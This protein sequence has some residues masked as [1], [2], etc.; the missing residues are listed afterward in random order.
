MVAVIFCTEISRH[1]NDSVSNQHW[2]S[3]SEPL[4]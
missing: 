2:T 4:Q 1:V 3:S